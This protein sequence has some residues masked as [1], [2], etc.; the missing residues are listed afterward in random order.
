ML[1]VR[2]AY[3]G[4]T[5]VSITAPPDILVARLAARGRGSDG[6]VADRLNRAVHDAAPDIT[7]MNVGSAEEHARQLLRAIR[8]V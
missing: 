2:S 1:A 5:V 7:I 4:V 6:P 8:G 3:A